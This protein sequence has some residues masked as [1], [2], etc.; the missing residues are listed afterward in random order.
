MKGNTN[1]YNTFRTSGLQFAVIVIVIT[2]RRFKRNIPESVLLL[3]F[4]FRKEIRE[5][6]SIR[7]PVVKEEK[8]HSRCELTTHEKRHDEVH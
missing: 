1:F 8:E 3:L 4:T 6:I 7:K 2:G 5:R